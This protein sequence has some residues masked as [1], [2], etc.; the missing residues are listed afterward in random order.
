MNKYCAFTICS[1][2]Y[3]AQ[4]FTLKESFK[5]HNQ[6]KDFFIFLADKID[7]SV[8]RYDEVIQLSTA[9]IPKWE[10]MAF[11]YNV[12]E[13]NTSIKPFCF[14]KLFS[15]GYDRVAYLDPDIYVLDSLDCVY[16]DLNNK[17]MVIT[18]HCTHIQ[19]DFTGAVSEEEILF[20]G[21]YNLGFCGIKNSEVGKKIVSWWMHR[22]EE[23]CYG[24]KVDALHV[25]QK[26]IDFL[27]GFYPEEIKISHHL[28]YNVAIWNLFERDLFIDKNA[29]YIKDKF[30]DLVYPL[31]FFHFSGFNPEN[32]TLLNRRQPKYNI[33]TYPSFKPLF[34]E[35]IQKETVNDYYYF[36]NLCYSFQ[37]YSNGNKILPLHRRIYGNLDNKQ[38]YDN[39]F[40]ANGKFYK[41]LKQKSLLSKVYNDTTAIFRASI[42][43]KDRKRDLIKKLFL[44]F[45][46]ILGVDKYQL[47]INAMFDLSR[48]KN[49]SFLLGRNFD[50]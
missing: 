22:L 4:A 27:P 1:K 9:F 45:K 48:N 20:V 17:D 8:K 7:S 23:R 12:I 21:I 44:I 34:E 36:N 14:N 46:K 38:L 33:E 39:P 47:L 28:G 42:N 18:P 6:D 25:D 2:N 32:P 3:L 11:K 24:D 50:D 35:Y 31:I 49:Q 41:L 15:D 37:Q 19:D 40:D 5:K 43:N 10:E 30:S 26:W 29:F 13:F 16:E